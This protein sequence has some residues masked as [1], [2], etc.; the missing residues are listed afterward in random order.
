MYHAGRWVESYQILFGVDDKILRLDLDRL[1]DG[2]K[3][4]FVC[5]VLLGANK[6]YGPTFCLWAEPDNYV[7]LSEVGHMVVAL[8]KSFAQS[9]QLF[10]TSHNPEDDADRQ[11][12]V[13]FESDSRL[14][15]R[16]M[17]VMPVA[18]G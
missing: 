5:A 11:V 10:V 17:Q 7:S 9:G 12:T 13:G 1:S 18:G 2:E 6:H 8:K 16:A 4:F 14:K 15:P 3:I